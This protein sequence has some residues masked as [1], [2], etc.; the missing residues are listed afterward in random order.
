M[1]GVTEYCDRG[2]LVLGIIK[3]V[4]GWLGLTLS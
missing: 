1:N 3:Q 2:V 4:H